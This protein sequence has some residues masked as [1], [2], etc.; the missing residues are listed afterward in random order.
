MRI[1]FIALFALVLSTSQSQVLISLLLGDKLNSDGLEFGLDGGLN[2]TNL[3]GTE[4]KFKRNFNLGFYFDVKFPNRNW[5]V[6]TGVIVK[7]NMGAKDLDVY[8]IGDPDIDTVFI[9]GSVERRLSYFNVPVMIKYMTKP[10]IYFEGGFMV[11]LNHGVIDLFKQKT[12]NEDDTQFANDVQNDFS[13]FDAGLMGGVGF[14]FRKSMGMYLGLRYYHGIYDITFG[15]RFPD[16]RN[17]SIYLAIGV[18]IGAG[19]A[20]EKKSEAQSEE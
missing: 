14:K 2:W 18:P 6:H 4:G 15:D 8:S 20:A 7:S 13:W 11:G 17:Q 12:F 10:R 9:G 5:M 16:Q 1:L 19:K 3:D